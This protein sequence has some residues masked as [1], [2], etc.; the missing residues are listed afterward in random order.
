MTPG[1]LGRLPDPEP[2]RPVLM[3]TP[4]GYI[5]PTPPPPAVDHLGL[6]RAYNDLGN[7][8]FGD[9]VIAAIGHM[10]E[11]DYVAA[12]LPDPGITVRAALEL[13]KRVNPDFDGIPGGPGDRGCVTQV[14]LD[15]LMRYGISTRFPVCFAKVQKDLVAIRVRHGLPRLQHAGRPAAPAERVELR[16]AAH[17]LGRSRGHV[18][19]VHDARAEQA[20]AGA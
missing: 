8:R 19:L 10:C 12:G 9:C 20:A 13:Y 17:G 1:L 18:G 11:V 7:K 16:R 5:P 6:V 3:L 4:R 15:R 14:A 2:N